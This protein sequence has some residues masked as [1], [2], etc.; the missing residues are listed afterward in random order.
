MN[1][2]EIV[3]FKVTVTFQHP[4]HDER[5]GIEYRTFARNKAQANRNIRRQASDD[6]HTTGRRAYFK[7]QQID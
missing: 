3:E 2:Q 4:A 1:Q 7:A 6:G 5:N